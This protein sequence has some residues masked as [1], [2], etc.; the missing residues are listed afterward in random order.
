[1]M[2]LQTRLT[3]K[4]YLNSIASVRKESQMLKPL[5]RRGE[6][7]AILTSKKSKPLSPRGEVHAIH[8]CEKIKPLSHRERGWGEG[9]A[10]TSSSENTYAV[11]ALTER[12]PGAASRRGWGEGKAY[13]PSSAFKNVQANC[14]SYFSLRNKKYSDGATP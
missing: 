14:A 6:L 13:T 12:G 5:S 8:T 1:M 3:C 9:N 7:H 4:P 11:H 10:N 2:E